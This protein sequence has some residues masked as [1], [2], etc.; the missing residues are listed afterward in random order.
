MGLKNNE[1]FDDSVSVDLS[2]WALLANR[3]LLE[4]IK[5]LIMGGLN[6]TMKKKC[7]T[8]V[9][10]IAEKQSNRKRYVK[11]DKIRRIP[12]HRCD[13]NSSMHP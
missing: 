2:S 10:M 6:S 5:G 9:N 11:D 12:L 7:L 1:A 4:I 3:S 8:Y 13:L